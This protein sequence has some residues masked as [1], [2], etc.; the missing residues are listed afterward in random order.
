MPKGKGKSGTTNLLEQK[1]WANL[2]RLLVWHSGDGLQNQRSGV[3]IQVSAKIMKKK[4]WEVR[5]RVK[6]GLSL[7]AGNR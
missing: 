6:A 4:N 7:V 1:I 5:V 3:Q 2:Q